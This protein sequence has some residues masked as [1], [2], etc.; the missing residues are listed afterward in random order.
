VVGSPWSVA[1][2]FSQRSWRQ[3]PASPPSVITPGQQV[4][5][6]ELS[7]MATGRWAAACVAGSMAGY[8]SFPGADAPGFMPSPASPAAHIEH[9]EF[10]DSG[11]FLPVKKRNHESTRIRIRPL[12]GRRIFPA[13]IG[14]ASLR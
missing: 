9:I 5:M 13:S 7:E 2:G 4:K 10:V 6:T 14:N 11:F 1:G 12:Q 3:R 8:V